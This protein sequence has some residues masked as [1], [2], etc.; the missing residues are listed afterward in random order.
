MNKFKAALLV[1]TLILPVSSPSA[2]AQELGNCRISSS[3]RQIVSLGFPLRPERL[4][5]LPKPN[6]LILPYV[7]SDETPFTLTDQEKDIFL[8]AGKKIY[9]YSSGQNQISFRFAP[10]IKIQETTDDINALKSRQQTSWGSNDYE[11]STYGFVSKIIKDSD[12]K[13]DYS[14]IDAVILFGNSTKRTEYIAEAMMYTNEFQFLSNSKRRGDETPWFSTIKTS[15]GEIK[16]AILLYNNTEA[17][18][19]TH[20][21]MHLYGLTDLYGSA[22]SPRYSLMSDVTYSLLPFEKWILG[23][24][25]DSKVQCISEKDEIS[26]NPLENQFSLNYADGDQSLVIPTGSTSSLNVD[27]FKAEGQTRL[28]FYLLENEDRPPIQCYYP[29]DSRCGAAVVDSFGGIG[30]QLSSPK[31]NLLISDNDG[32][33]VVINLVLNSQLQSADFAQLV[34][35]AKNNLIQARTKSRELQVATTRAAA[36]K[37]AAEKAAADKAAVKPLTKQLSITC[38]KGKSPVKIVGTNPRCPTG[39]KVKK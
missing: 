17:R 14:G 34:Q 5:A 11:K 6:I 15:E 3:S 9:E 21:L 27:V 31:Y 30:T 28:I 7:Q 1:F 25:P 29:A 4:A 38:L 20:E 35:T 2:E 37:A 23:W 39:Y 22:M 24:L 10:T 16:N 33:K 8:E 26:P 19:V 36:E 13:I 12:S 32:T 18:T